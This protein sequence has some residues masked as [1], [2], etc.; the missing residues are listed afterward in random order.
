VVA[1]HSLID[2]PVQQQVLLR[3]LQNSLEHLF[4]TETFGTKNYFSVVTRAD[5]RVG[6]TVD[7]RIQHRTAEFVAIGG[8]IGP[9]A[10]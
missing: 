10:G 6:E 2:P 7:Y 1:H 3:Q 9:A 5:D 8:E 4:A